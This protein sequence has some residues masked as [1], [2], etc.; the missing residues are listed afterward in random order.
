MLNAQRS[1][2]KLNKLNAKQE[3]KNN[4]DYTIAY[5]AINLALFSIVLYALL[6]N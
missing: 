3:K 1:T 6:I 5:I 2:F 4:R